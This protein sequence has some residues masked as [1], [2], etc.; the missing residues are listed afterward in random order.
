MNIDFPE[1]EI[2][3]GPNPQQLLLIDMV[4]NYAFE[5]IAPVGKVLAVGDS[6]KK[7]GMLD[8]PY[9]RAN[10]DKVDSVGINLDRNGCGQYKHFE[11][12]YGN[13]HDMRWESESFDC[14]LSIMMLEHDPEFWLSLGEM[15]RVLRKNGSLIIAIPGFVN[16]GSSNVTSPSFHAG[17]GTIV[18]ESHGDPDCYRFSPHW[19]KY[20][21]FKDF[22]DVSVMSTKI[23]QP[24][25][26]V[27]MG[28][29]L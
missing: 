17:N 18:Y 23:L 8:L 5:K 29:K 11:V 6:A 13:A 19:F 7:N 14:V 12:E 21:V 27:G 15:K 1:K 24:P 25:R 3:E 10:I 16:C 26:I 4:Y 20:V 2:I 28:Y 22:R 9:F